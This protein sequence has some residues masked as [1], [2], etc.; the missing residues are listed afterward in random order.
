M[1]ERELDVAMRTARDAGELALR[2]F[3]SDV[4]A[5]EKEDLSPV[6]EADRECEKVI[7]RVLSENFPEDGIV[8][9]EGTFV[10]SR[11]G[12]RWLIDPIDGTRDFVRRMPF[13]S[14]QVA[15]QV[16]AE[17][18]LG[19]IY[20]P[21]L[22]EIAHAALGS[23]CHWNGVR[24]RASGISQVEKAILTV[25]GFRSVWDAWPPDAVRVL[26][27]KCWTVRAYS[28]CYDVVMLARGKTDIWLSGSGMEWDYAAA[29]IAAR[30]SGAQFLI[31][32]G[33]DR[34]DAGHCLICAP[35]LEPA[36]RKILQIP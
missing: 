34:I 23:G 20:L 22:N 27:E 2:Y 19:V 26:T 11:S 9:E 16:D 25:S 35:G 10:S 6:T 14:V 13:W 36:L 12:R 5:E 3:A 32:D 1:Y 17:V 29:R 33:S 24:I 30:E 8:G 4:R 28:G 7:G 31:R 21:S 18:V 15:L